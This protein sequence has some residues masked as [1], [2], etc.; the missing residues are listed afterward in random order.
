LAA[1]QIGASGAREGVTADTYWPGSERF[2]ELGGIGISA[3]YNMSG[4]ICGRVVGR[5]GTLGMLRGIHVYLVIRV[6]N[7][8]AI[9]RV[10]ASASPPPHPPRWA[11]MK[12]C[13]LYQSLC[14]WSDTESPLIRTVL[15]IPLYD[16]ICTT[17]VY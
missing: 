12:N 15:G 13:V 14:H 9:S 16:F 11:K 3:P 10:P 2:L 6:I 5:L 8:G 4:T 17:H 1:G 7:M